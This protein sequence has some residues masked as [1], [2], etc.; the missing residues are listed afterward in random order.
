MGA[1]APAKTTAGLSFYVQQSHWSCEVKAGT[2]LGSGRG[3]HGSCWAKPDGA[4]SLHDKTAAFAELVS[5]VAGEAAPR[6]QK[7][8]P[9]QGFGTAGLWDLSGALTHLLY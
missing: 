4:A 8:G 7:S 6:R 1:D 3:V 2:A 5:P 9:G